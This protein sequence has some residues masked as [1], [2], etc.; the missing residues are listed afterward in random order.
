MTKIRVYVSGPSREVARCREAVARLAEVGIEAIGTE[1][2]DHVERVGVGQEHTLPEPAARLYARDDLAHV[3]SAD[4]VVA[5]GYG[6][7][8]GTSVGAAME[9]G[10][11]LASGVP[12]LG[13]TGPGGTIH[14]LFRHLFAAELEWDAGWE[15]WVAGWER[16]TFPPPEEQE[17]LR[18]PEAPPIDHPAVVR[19][20]DAVAAAV[21]KL[22]DG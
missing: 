16:G 20:K 13:V 5:L 1:W 2:M 6:F 10:C 17:P 11:A 12:V 7:G 18:L 3:R 8:V 21:A 19:P 9:I 14:S 15:W 4:L 22:G